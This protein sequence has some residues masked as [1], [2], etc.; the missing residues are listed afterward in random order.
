MSLPAASFLCLLL[1]VS[2]AVRLSAAG[3]D[4]IRIE[5]DSSWGGLG[6]PTKGTLVITGSRGK[7]RSEERKIDDQAV[8]S[9]LAALEQPVADQ[10]LIE[11]CGIT[12]RWLLANYKGGLK[13]YTHRKLGDLPPEGVSLFKNPLHQRHDGTRC[14]R[15]STPTLNQITLRERPLAPSFFH[16]QPQFIR[17][18]FIAGSGLNLWQLCAREI[19]SGPTS[20]K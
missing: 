3:P 19:E 6:A 18:S 11:E 7:Y 9:L 8:E 20:Q 16:K 12:Q 5:I 4:A 14:I 17:H 1:A 2:S 15:R 13:D 10:P